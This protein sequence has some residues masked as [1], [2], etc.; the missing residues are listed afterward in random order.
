M[1]VDLKSP[2]N[3]TGNHSIPSSGVV[4]GADKTHVSIGGKQ[5]R[6]ILITG[7]INVD[8]ELASATISCDGGEW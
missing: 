8:G 4:T 3:S 7:L 2:G 6:E 5:V 1:N